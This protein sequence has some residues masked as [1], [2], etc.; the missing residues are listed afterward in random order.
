MAGR[1]TMPLRIGQLFAPIW[2]SLLFLFG[3]VTIVC[4]DCECGYTVGSTLYTEILE[5][6]FLH[7][8]NITLDTDWQP[9]N[10][11]V[12]PE[13]SRGPYGKNASLTNVLSNPL[14][15]N[16]SWS[17]NGVLGGDG[18]LQLWVRGGVSRDGL[19]P[20]AEVDTIRRDMYYGSF[21]IAMK[22][23]SIPGTCG[24]FF[25]VSPL[26]CLLSH[27][28]TVGFLVLQRYPRNRYGV[29]L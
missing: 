26:D 21:R 16:N 2:L 3:L 6:D 12:T 22:L 23:T 13:A 18:G 20:M 19:V 24:A 4:G 8:Q 1:R 25:W 17:G 15:N 7:L 29:P 5:T 28:L 10:Y 11:T 27:K 14:G 9:Q